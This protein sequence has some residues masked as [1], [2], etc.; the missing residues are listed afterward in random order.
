MTMPSSSGAIVAR[1]SALMKPGVRALGHLEIAFVGGDSDRAD[2]VAADV[3]VAADQR[4]QPARVGVV[5][6]AGVDPEPDRAFEPGRGPGS[7]RSRR[8]PA[9]ECP[10]VPADRCAESGRALQ[11]WLRGARRSISCSRELPVLLI[12]LDWRGH[13]F[14]QPLAVLRADLLGRRRLDPFG[15][16]A[17]VAQHRS[18]P[19]GGG[20]T[21]RSARRC[22]CGRRGRSGRN[23]AGAPRRRAEVRRG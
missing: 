9:R 11:R 7:P 18:R 4:Q 15:L 2:V 21:A 1:R 17:C 6:A 22:P 12:D 23:G 14:Q 5:A 8:A 16:D 19:C 3:A 10:P 13:R 20:G